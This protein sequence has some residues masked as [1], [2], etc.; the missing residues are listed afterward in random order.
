MIDPLKIQNNYIVNL[1]KVTFGLTTCATFNMINVHVFKAAQA[2]RAYFINIWR[3]RRRFLSGTSPLPYYYN[4]CVNA[5]NE[6]LFLL[7]K[8]KQLNLGPKEHKWHLGQ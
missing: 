7:K 2:R 1:C 4:M 5:S 8:Q 3:R 6:V